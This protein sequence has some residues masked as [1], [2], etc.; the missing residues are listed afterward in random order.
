MK[1]NKKIANINFEIHLDENNIPEEI[2]WSATDSENKINKA[3]AVI[4]S[5]WDGKAKASL[6]I[7]LWTKEMM[8]EEMKF[9][10]VQILD[11]LADSYQKSVGD[12]QVSVKIRNFAK[13]IGQ[14]S[15][16]LK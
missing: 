7:D 13:K 8:A 6:K 5:I 1:K 14:I 15:K 3:K 12:E 2:Q 9:F 4:I 16:V 10:T 11:A